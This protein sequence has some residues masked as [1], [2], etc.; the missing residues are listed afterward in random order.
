MDLVSHEVPVHLF[1]Q[2]VQV[3]LNGSETFCSINCFFETADSALSPIV[4]GIN[5]DI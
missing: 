3:P 1:F 2:P 5:E 4:Q